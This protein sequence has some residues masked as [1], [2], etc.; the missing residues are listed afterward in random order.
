MPYIGNV[1]SNRSKIPLQEFRTACHITTEPG[2]VSD[3]G[4]LPD[5]YGPGMPRYLPTVTSFVPN[6]PLGSPL[7]VSVHSWEAPIAGPD[8]VALAQQA[9]WIWFE[10]SVLIDG[11][12]T[13]G[14][15]FNQQASWP[16]V[17][18]TCSYPNKDG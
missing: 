18:D 7:N 9:D 1:N 4:G 12:C 17:I 13:A 6:I 8:T 3:G 11:M 2:Q 10:A 14:T 5:S 15:F 16:Q